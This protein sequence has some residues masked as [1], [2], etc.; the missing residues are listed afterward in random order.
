MT[1]VRSAPPASVRQATLTLPVG[2]FLLAL[3]VR[4]SVVALTVGWS[5]PASAEPASDSRIHMEL[6]QNL[7]GGRGY[8]LDGEPVASTPPLYI[9]FLAALY[10]VFGSPVWVRG[11][12]VLLGA[13]GVLVLYATGRRIL[14]EPTALFG[15]VLLAVHPAAAYLA[16][17]HLTENLFLPLL[18]LGILQAQCLADRPSAGGALGLGALVGLGALARAVFLGFVPFVLLWSA[19]RWGVRN[20]LS[21]RT[22]GLVVAGCVLAVLPWTVR[23]VLVL[24]AFVPVQSNG[25]L[26][27]W[28]ANNPHADGGLVW[29]TR[30]T[31][32]GTRPPDDGQYGWRDLRVSEENALYFR[33]ALRWIRE[34]PEDYLRLLGRKLARLYGFA[35]ATDEGEL[36]V[37]LAVAVFQVL[38]YLAAAAGWILAWVRRKPVALLGWL[39]VFTN[40][41]ALVF[42][43][44]SRYALPMLPSLVLFAAFALRNAWRWGEE[45]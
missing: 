29:P 43:G 9:F 7:L 10:A 14:D 41:M 33:E 37:P 26:V 21:Y 31:W 22:G 16:G 45:G 44:A 32:T 34:H 4:T 3:L 27:F 30:R 2:I 1:G 15:A 35:R 8:T 28:A 18:L 13:A 25:A 23:N 6:T 17:L 40:L 12:Q 11:V 19:L 5:A 24:R 42:S 39:V 20:R 36:S 38:L